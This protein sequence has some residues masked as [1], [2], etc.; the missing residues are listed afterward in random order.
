ML[1]LAAPPVA[2]EVR[3]AD[4]LVPAPG[5]WSRK[6][7]HVK[8]LR[9][10]GTHLKETEFDN[11]QELVTAEAASGVTRWTLSIGSATESFV[12]MADGRVRMVESRS[13]QKHP[14]VREYPATLG[15]GSTYF[16]WSEN[17]ARGHDVKLRAAGREFLRAAGRTFDTIVFEG[18]DGL[19]RFKTWQA[20]GFG[21]IQSEVRSGPVL[22][23][24]RKLV[25]IEP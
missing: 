25:R 3:I 11:L 10:A 18:A 23:S 6:R 2:A 24:R 9:W 5:V 16:E 21:E 12:V 7:F 14:I 17:P 20:R 15:A 8:A 1:P 22:V 13:R 4:Y 19:F